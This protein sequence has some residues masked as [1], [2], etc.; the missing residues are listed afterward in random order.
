MVISPLGFE[1]AGNLL[2]RRL[3]CRRNS[4][5]IRKEQIHE[6]RGSHRPAKL[7]AKI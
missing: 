6:D 4:I 7:A 3:V 2:A 5:G 1:H